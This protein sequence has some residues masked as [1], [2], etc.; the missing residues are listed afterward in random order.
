MHPEPNLLGI[1]VP[2]HQPARI[3]AGWNHDSLAHRPMQWLH[4]QN[5]SEVWLARGLSPAERPQPLEADFL[6]QRHPC[7]TMH[8]E[9]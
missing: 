6:G 3:G 5:S 4:D 8:T 1:W 9:E 7:M 2:C